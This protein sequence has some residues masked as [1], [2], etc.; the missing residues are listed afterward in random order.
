MRNRNLF[1][2]K[3]IYLIKAMST[4][5]DEKSVFFLGIALNLK[6]NTIKKLNHLSYFLIYF[7]DYGG[8]ILICRLLLQIRKYYM[9][10]C[11]RNMLAVSKY[12]MFIQLNYK[13]YNRSFIYLD[14]M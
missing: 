3:Y 8:H 6:Y 7:K 2:I 11:I 13:D 4:N 10:T 9:C 12:L 14:K 5:Q 1:F